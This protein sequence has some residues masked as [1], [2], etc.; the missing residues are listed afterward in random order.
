MKY[1]RIHVY[2]YTE[3][4][5]ASDLPYQGRKPKHIANSKKQHGG[6]GKRW[7]LTPFPFFVPWPYRP[8]AIETPTR[9]VPAVP[10]I[11]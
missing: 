5:F 1:I 11:S 7:P 3:R 4:M 2:E 10:L 6:D 8:P 9:P